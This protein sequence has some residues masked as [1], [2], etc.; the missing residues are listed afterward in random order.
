MRQTSYLPMKVTINQK[1][2]Q[3]LVQGHPWIFRSDLLKIEASEPGPVSVYSKEDRLLGQA[4]YSP[5]S[6]IALR[7]MTKGEA[8]IDEVLIRE[9]MKQAIAWRET[10]LPEEK[11]RRLIFGEAD[12]LPSLIVEQYHGSLV[13]QTLSAGM[14]IYKESIVEFLKESLEPQC[15]IERNDVPSRDLEG[16]EK[17]QQIYWSQAEPESQVEILGKNYQVDC[18][19]GQKT[20]FFLDQRFNA[21]RVG[22]YLKGKLL[23]AFSHSGQFAFQAGPRVEQILCVDQSAEAIQAISAN[24]KLN[25]DQRVQSRQANVFDFLKEADQNQDCYDSIVLDPPAFV[26]SKAALKKAMAGYKEI[27][28]RALK[29]LRSEGILASFSCSQ[30]LS[31]EDFL[32]VLTRAAKDAKRQV[33]VIEEFSQPPDHPW[34][35]NIPE[36]HYLKGFLLRVL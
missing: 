5:K 21:Q 13:F 33:Q 19:S 27:N 18:L 15:I 24:A 2:W 8:K 36:T 14:E 26:K 16:L 17:I 25:S 10:T 22:S 11:C 32:Q 20:G 30:N 1:A 12:G 4:L 23:D 35:P 6:R 34:R 29:I 3:R 28:L 7:M 31:R 9:R